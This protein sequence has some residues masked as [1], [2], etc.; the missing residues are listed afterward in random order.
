M[1]WALRGVITVHLL[2]VSAQAVLAGRFL[3]GDYDMLSAHAD[4]G[5]ATTLVG[6]IQLIVALASLGVAL[7]EP[8]QIALGL[9]RVTGVHL[10]MG[11]LIVTAV[12]LLTVWVWRPEAARRRPA[13]ASTPDTA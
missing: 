9:G 1:R 11:V 4:N 10:P 7:A 3:S 12:A 8:T 5:I 6:V 2:G 13:P